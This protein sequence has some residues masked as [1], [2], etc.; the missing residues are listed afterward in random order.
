M[1]SKQRNRGINFRY[2]AVCTAFQV[3][4]VRQ[5]RYFND[6]RTASVGISGKRSTTV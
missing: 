1:G 4:N 3:H 2:F 6:T 5:F